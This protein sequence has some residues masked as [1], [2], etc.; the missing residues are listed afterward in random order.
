MQVAVHLVFPLADLVLEMVEN[1]ADAGIDAGGHRGADFLEMPT[2]MG[3]ERLVLALGVGR[4]RVEPLGGRIKALGEVIDLPRAELAFLLDLLAEL[5]GLSEDL[6]LGLLKVLEA[7][8][9][10]GS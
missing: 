4:R 10:G 7:S 8:G 9:V 3:A 2:E 1:F 5:L 6:G